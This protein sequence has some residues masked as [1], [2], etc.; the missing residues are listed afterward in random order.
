MR[1]QFGY[2]LKYLKGEKTL[3]EKGIL[4]NC[5][6]VYFGVGAKKR[7]GYVKDVKSFTR[8][9]NVFSSS[10]KNILKLLFYDLYLFVGFGGGLS[11]QDNLTIK[12]NKF[13]NNS[14]NL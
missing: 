10:K 7:Y 6:Y 3:N 4:L 12:E 11:T 8:T 1:Q 9:N 13:F 2:I 5:V 14:C